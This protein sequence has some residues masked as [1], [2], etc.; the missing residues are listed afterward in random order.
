LNVFCV[1][2]MCLSEKMQFLG[3]MFCKVVQNHYIEVRRENN[4]LDIHKSIKIIFGRNV[5]KKVRNQIM[6]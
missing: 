2:T 4:N 1:F 3:F 5:T 6:I